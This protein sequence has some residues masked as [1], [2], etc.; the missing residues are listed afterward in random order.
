M[1]QPSRTPIPALLAASMPSRPWPGWRSRREAGRGTSRP[2][3]SG[4]APV[5]AIPAAAG[6]VRNTTPAQAATTHRRRT[7]AGTMGIRRQRTMI[8]SIIYTL[9]GMGDDRLW[10]IFAI[11]PTRS[12]RGSR[13]PD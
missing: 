6:S 4:P 8:G 2:Y 5:S 13:D 3:P 9:Q 7:D 11:M 10:V 1:L 12:V